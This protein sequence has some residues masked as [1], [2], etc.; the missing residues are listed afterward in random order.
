MLEASK[1]QTR[2]SGVLFTVRSFISTD[3]GRLV[4]EL[5]ALRVDPRTASKVMKLIREA[6]LSSEHSADQS[7]DD[8]VESSVDSLLR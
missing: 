7:A 8:H 1:R 6:N 3:D 5:Q 4:T 2:V